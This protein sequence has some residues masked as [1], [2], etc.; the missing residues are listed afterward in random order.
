MKRIKQIFALLLTCTL[1]FSLCACGNSSSGGGTKGQTVKIGI[2][3]WPGSYWWFAVNDLGYF[4]AQG[5]DVEL[6]L[7]SNYADGINALTSGSID[8]FVPSLADLIPGYMNGANVKVIMIQD[9]SAGA[10]G[11]IASS[12]ITSIADLKGK[13]VAMEFGGSDHLFL[14]K[15][16]ENAGLSE[17]DVNLVNMSTGD[18]SNAF[19]SGSVDAAA[20][21]EPSLS[22]AQAETGGNILATTADPEYEG[23]IPAVLAAN[24]DSLSEKRDE[25][26]LVMKAWFN[27]QDAYTNNQDEFAA[28]VE[29]H[30][31]VTADE[32]L[33]LMGGCNV[34]SLEENVLAFQDGDTYV[35]LNTCLQILG[36]FSY[37]N[38]LI[39]TIPEDY[40]GLVDSSL[41]EEVYSDLKK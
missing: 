27:A 17:N 11:L 3:D 40:S 39:D 32:F 30:T 10:D 8:L 6:Q 20:I 1:L 15:C 23:L 9:F 21:W 16:L 34:R 31:E 2:N 33:E 19:I 12:D 29:A 7:F 35:S 5:V 18:A 4:E 13:N 36:S 37:D 26:K 28:A 24:T 25:I 22:M 38:G 41:F 14:L